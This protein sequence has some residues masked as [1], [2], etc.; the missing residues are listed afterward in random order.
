MSP[1]LTGLVGIIILLLL[2]AT[3]MP[4][5]FAMLLLGFLGYG[6]LVTWSGA[7]Y[8]LAITSYNVV[9]SYDFQVIALFILMAGICISSGFSK[10]L[11]NMAHVV[12]GRLRGSLALATLLTCALF[13]AACA[14]SA[15]TAVTVGS[16]AIPEMSRYKYAKS[17]ATGTVAAGGTLGILIPPSGVLIIYGIITQQSIGKLFIAGL[18]PGIILAFLLIAVTYTMVK[19]NPKLA[20]AGEKTSLKTKLKAVGS[21]FE[22]L[23]LIFFV[24]GGLIVGWF[25]PT[26]AGA[27]GAFGAIVFSLI[28]RKMGWEQLKYVTKDSFI[29]MG[30][31]FAILIGALVFSN[32]I[33]ASTIPMELAGWVGGLPLPPLSIL[34]IIILIYIFLGCFIDV[35]SIIVLTI[36]IF[37]P[38]VTQIGYD[39]I[40]FGIVIV[41]VTEMGLITPP[42]GMGVYLIAGMGETTI[43]TV[44]KGVTPYIIVMLLFIALITAFPQIVLFLPSIS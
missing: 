33:A 35:M 25:S 21:C 18:I 27:A 37:Y 28:R 43:Q 9:S 12:L 26:E 14:S 40:W 24:I 23:A 3:G 42:V 41:L 15:A 16:V 29:I 44:F 17:L 22:M 34:I 8:N 5:G 2:M 11:F 1:V 20:P 10:S 36:P 4:V 19:L 7:T 38:V 32:F 6:Y 39:P 13:A 30:M 31:L